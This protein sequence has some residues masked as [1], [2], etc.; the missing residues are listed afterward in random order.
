MGAKLDLESIQC[1]NIF[2][3]VTGVRTKDCFI[4]NNTRV[5]VVMPPLLPRALGEKGAN[6]KQLSY[7]LRGRVRIL[8]ESNIENFVRMLVMP[9]KFKKLIVEEDGTVTII[10]GQQAKA[11]LIGRDKVR[12]GE[13]N[14]ILKQYY[15]I[16]SLKIV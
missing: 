2:S 8:P 13:L 6:I 11:S 1:I 5:F 15:N 4:Y 9:V 14:D 16:K 12:L 7:L 10:A 3:K